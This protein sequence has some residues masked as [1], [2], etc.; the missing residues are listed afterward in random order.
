MRNLSRGIFLG[1][2]VAFPVAAQQT[3]KNKIQ[4][5][6]TENGQRMCGDYVPQ[7]YIKQG[8]QII[9]DGR[10][11]QTT[12][13]AKSAEELEREARES[14]AKKARAERDRILTEAYHD[15]GDLEAARDQRL[16]FIDAYLTNAEKSLT[17]NEKALVEMQARAA[18]DQEQDKP[19]DEALAAQIAQFERLVREQQ[20]TLEGPRQER[21]E[22]ERRFAEDIARFHEL[23]PDAA[24]ATEKTTEETAEKNSGTEGGTPAPL[25]P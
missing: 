6:T 1:V 5:W 10:V 22:V 17:V 4:C 19:V 14:A 25:S 18:A 15:V 24:P 11:V 2:L 21:K 8:R 23:K 13:A 7:Q 12:E 3:N 9:Q 20:A 16:A